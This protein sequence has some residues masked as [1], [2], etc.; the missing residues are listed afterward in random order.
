MRPFI[1][2]SFVQVHYHNRPGGVNKVIGQ[3]AKAQAELCAKA[4]PQTLFANFIIGKN[5]SKDGSAFPAG[6]MRDVPECDYRVFSTKDVFLN[7]RE[8]LIHRLMAII[9]SGSVPKPLC[10]VGHN[11]T[12]GKNCALSSAFAHCARSC[13]HLPDEVRF[14]SV[15]HDFAEEGR[16]DCL[17]QIYDLQNLGI[18]IWNELYPKT[19]NLSFVALNKHNYVLLKKSGFNVEMLSNPV[20]IEKVKLH[21]VVLKKREAFKKL[22]RY[23]NSE[24]VPIDPALPT[25]FYPARV[26]SRKNIIEAVLVCNI[27]G[28]A[29]LLVGKSGSSQE[30]KAL[31][32]KIKRLCLKHKAR[33]VF[34]C[35]AAFARRTIEN[36]FPS[37]LYDVADACISTS[38][39]EGFGYAF[40]EPWINNKYITGR[41]PVDFSPVPGMKFPGLYS[42]MP[43]PVSW[44]L[45][46][47][48]ARKYYDR[49]RQFYHVGKVKRFSSFLRFKP[50]FKAAFIKNDAIDFGCLDEATQLNVANRLM[51]SKSMVMEW[52]RLCGK[53][54]KKIQ[55]AVTM[56]FLPK[57]SLIRS[58]QDT[59][60]KKVSGEKFAENFAQCFFKARIKTV[61]Q[62][63]YK[64]IARYFGDLSRFRLLITPEKA[65]R[66]KGV[67]KERGE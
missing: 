39:S 7:T 50:E 9:Q 14:F 26:I 10:I 5:D 62:N 59:I 27:I 3:Y 30:H 21:R 1:A 46:D 49:L 53:E 47:D 19:N 37:L 43:V 52:E 54:L 48:C 17:K 56:G 33:V 45:I 12:L 29:N 36:G 67:D 44:I 23:S 66:A 64:E 61:P 25:L 4:S 11:L 40:Y 35:S 13:E 16:I 31:F 57:Q 8:V 60:K 18:D 34:D 65:T 20:E 32:T 38:I 42:R 58:N 55:D 6:E 24:Q 22:I 15:I 28:K 51:E 41:K 63:R 2:R